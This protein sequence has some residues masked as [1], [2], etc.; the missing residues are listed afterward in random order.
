M[1]QLAQEVEY[2]FRCPVCLRYGVIDLEQLEGKVSIICS[3]CNWHG[4]KS[5]ADKIKDQST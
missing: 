3:F 1:E 5:D 4:Y 2:V